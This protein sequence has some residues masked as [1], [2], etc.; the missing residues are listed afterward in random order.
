MYKIKNATK[1]L[2]LNA[3][4]DNS[5]TKMYI[6]CRVT[7]GV[8]DLLETVSASKMTGNVNV[9]PDYISTVWLSSNRM[10]I[11]LNLIPHTRLV[12]P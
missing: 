7:R 5:D 10:K 3:A 6:S 4:I 8:K 9:L 1:K 11:Y 12:I 2:A